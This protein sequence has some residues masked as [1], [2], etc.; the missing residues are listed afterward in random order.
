MTGLVDI[1]GRGT[2]RVIAMC[3]EAG[4]APPMFVEIT[5]AAVVTCKVNV[6]RSRKWI[7]H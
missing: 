6:K 1:Q 4:I 3:R 7:K 2:N 5:G